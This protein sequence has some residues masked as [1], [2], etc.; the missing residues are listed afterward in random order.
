VHDV[1][2]T[3]RSEFES[4]LLNLK[5]SAL[6]RAILQDEGLPEEL[7]DITPRLCMLLETV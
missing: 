4:Q 6:G 1:T 2:S 7:R 5:S 3:L